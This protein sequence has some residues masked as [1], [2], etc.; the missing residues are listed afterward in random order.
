MKVE[1]CITQVGINKNS[2]SNNKEQIKNTSKNFSQ[3]KY[4]A[5]PD[6]KGSLIVLGIKKRKEAKLKAEEQ[7]LMA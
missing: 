5:F 6:F 1:K 4:E 7:E 2:S 3:S